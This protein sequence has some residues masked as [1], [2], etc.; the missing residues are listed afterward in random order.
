MG[1]APNETTL[2]V[3]ARINGVG[4]KLRIANAHPIAEGEQNLVFT[5][6]LR[7]ERNI[8]KATDSRHRDRRALETQL[9]MLDALKHR[10]ANVCASLPIWGDDHIFEVAVEGVPFYLV[11][12]RYAAG[13]RAEIT[14]HGHRMGQALAEL[15]DAM[16]RLPRYAFAEITSDDTLAA[17][18]E[19]ARTLGVPEKT[20]ASALEY[21]DS[22]DMQ[23]LHG[24]FNSGNLKID[25]PA[26]NIFDFDNCV[27]GNLAYELG[28]SLYMV[29]FDQVRQADGN[30]ARY[31]HF[32]RD[33]LEGYRHASHASPPEP[34]IDAYISYR[35]LLLS[36]WL[37]NPDD[38][39]FFVRQSPSSWLD[40]LRTF[41]RVYFR[42]AQDKLK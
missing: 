13:K 41:V 7:G 18:G 32:R 12:Y 21:S 10:F 39:P 24:D 35:V 36:S 3:L 30:L 23:L 27:Y 25:G 6:S 42:S 28:N 19:A 29:L 34:V 15:H 33:F 1:A 37:Q 16:R 11:A 14:R 22:R 40:T 38:A 20:Y 17:V 9:A 8:L 31:R 5:C 26:V 2:N 4:A